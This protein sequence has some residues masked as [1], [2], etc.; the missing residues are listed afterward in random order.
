LALRAFTSRAVSDE[1]L[2][3]GWEDGGG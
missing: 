1:V 3:G 2:D